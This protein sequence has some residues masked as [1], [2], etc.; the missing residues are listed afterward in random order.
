MRILVVDPDPGVQT[1]FSAWLAEAGHDCQTAGATDDALALAMRVPH[2]TAIV[3]ID[4]DAGRGL[5]LARRLRHADDVGMI[6]LTGSPSYAAGVSAMRMGANDYLVKPCRRLEVLD[7]VERAEAWREGLQRD[8][9]ARGLMQEALALAR[10]RSR[11]VAQ[12]SAADPSQ[13]LQALTAA[14]KA[15][16]PE[17]LE[18]S[19][20]VSRLAVRLGRSL[21]LKGHVL[22][23]LEH[24]ALLH[25]VGKIAVADAVLDTDRP[26]TDPELDILRTH[27]TLGFQIVSE[28]PALRH[29]APVVVATN[30][31]FDGSGLPAGLAGEEIPLGARIIAVADAWDTLATASRTS[32]VSADAVNAELVRGAGADFDPDVIRTW[33]SV[34]EEGL[35]S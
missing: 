19:Q 11:L 13:A 23:D 27:V 1:Q 20:R 10:D 5:S 24:A 32:R 9:S 2:D 21:G 17:T 7:A 29:L 4:L 14:L 28:V 25:D 34:G 26:L 30:E 12:A 18:H 6:L 33:L 16:L 3:N 31:R 8:R 22:E 15:R 35:C